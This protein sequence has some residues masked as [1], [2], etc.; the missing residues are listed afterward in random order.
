MKRNHDLRKIK[1]KKGY[2]T[3]ELAEAVG[4]HLQTV[5]NWRRDGLKP[6]DPDSH[7]SLFIGS[8]IKEYL[9]G[10]MQSRRV[11]LEPNEFYCFGCREKTTSLKISRQS[12]NRKIGTDKISV[13]LKGRCVKCGKE[14]NKF[15]SKSTKKANTSEVIKSGLQMS[16]YHSHK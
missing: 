2:S 8:D 9:Y 15:S 1:A 11:K 6:I 12:Q 7:Y 4:V 13:I 14:V 10:L 16:L 3:Q 5:R